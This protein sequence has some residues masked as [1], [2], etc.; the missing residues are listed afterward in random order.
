MSHKNFHEPSLL[1]PT[2]CYYDHERN[3]ESS[4]VK[5][6]VEIENRDIKYIAKKL[7]CWFVDQDKLIDK[8]DENFVDSI[9]F[10]PIGMKK[11]AQNFG[12][13]ILEIK[14]WYVWFDW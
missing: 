5:E 3:L 14:E 13:T 7:D 9:H 4:R 11:L 1:F 8:K 10:T 12:D 6:G 2:F